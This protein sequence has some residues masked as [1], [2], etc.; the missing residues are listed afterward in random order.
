MKRDATIERVVSPR[1]I[2]G[3]PAMS[4]YLPK[5]R[6]TM[7]DETRVTTLG[8]DPE[9]NHGIV[10]PP[11]YHA[12]TI[13][14][15]SL[16]AYDAPRTRDG[17]YYGRYGTPTT[18]ALT[19]AV[20]T[21]EGGHSGFAVSSGKNAITMVLMGLTAAGDHVLVTD[22]AYQPTRDTATRVAG[23]FGVEVEFFD[24]GI[25]A[26]IAELMRPNTR[27][28][29][30]ESPGSLTF[31][32]QDV[33]A[34]ADVAH[35]HGA[36]VAIDNTWASPLFCKPFALGVDISIQAVTKYV[37]GHSD[38]MMGLVSTTAE[39]EPR[40]RAAFAE[41]GGA[42][43]PEDCYLALR[44]LRTLSARLE[45][46]QRSA[47]AVAEWLVGR[48][49]VERVLYP[50]LPE[51]PGHALWRRDFTGASGL[52]GFL[53]MP[54]RRA[55]LAAMLDHLEIFGMGASWGGYESLLIPTDPRPIRTAR[56][57]PHQGQLMR[58]HVGL[59]HPDDLIR[60]LEAGFARLAAAA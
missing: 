53:L 9:K 46:H 60:D 7:H 36:V 19:D 41:F 3:Q 12:S 40:V 29:F 42:P 26:G 48:P 55:A 17:Y 10:N 30:L 5:A 6:F 4:S 22:S 35:A 25:G 2:I 52:F 24:P 39:L 15:P 11:V 54:V 18:R 56:P 33:P 50:A 57:W 20:A 37:G 47:L 1:L 44:G 16:A 23:R 31:E 8:R 58:I 59:E 13:L 21:L 28:V 51:D 43:G 49:E 32:V 34:I 27:L 38:L 14:F 45:R